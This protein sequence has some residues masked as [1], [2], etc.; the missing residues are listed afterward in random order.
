MSESPAP[1]RY[2][3]ILPPH[4]DSDPVFKTASYQERMRILFE[5][6]VRERLYTAAAALVSLPNAART[7][8]YKDLSAS[9]SLNRL[10]KK[11]IAHIQIAT[12]R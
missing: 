11:F 6:M 1:F 4:F 3:D 9:T 5:R 10:L 2:A 7:G 12:G 8:K